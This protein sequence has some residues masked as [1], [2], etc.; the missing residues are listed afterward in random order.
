MKKVFLNL[1]LVAS[2]AVGSVA[3][4]Q[5]AKNKTEAKEAEKAAEKSEMAE[6]FRVLAPESDIK[7]EGLKKTGSGHNGKISIE[8]GMFTFTDGSIESGKFVINMES[9]NVEDLEGDKKA[10]LE[11]HLKGTVEGKEGD[12]FNVQEFPQAIFEVTE[13]KKTDDNK[14]LMLGNLQMKGETKNIEVPVKNI[15]KNGDFIEFTTEEF[16]IDRTKWGVNYGSKSVFDNLVGDNIIN[17]EIGLQIHIKA[18]KQ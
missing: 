11:A 9:I 17:D 4:Q 14:T 3:C 16:A 6:E 15:E 7:W 8:K 10:K 12:F 18:K 5:D 2:V 13:V 1:A